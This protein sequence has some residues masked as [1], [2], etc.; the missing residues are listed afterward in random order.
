MSTTDISTQLVS[1]NFWAAD[2]LDRD[3]GRIHTK[4]VVSYYKPDLWGG[5]HEFKAGVD[6][7]WGWWNDGG[8]PAGGSS[9]HRAGENNIIYRQ[10][11]NN[12]VPFQLTTKNSPVKPADNGQYLGVYGPGR[13]DDRPTAD[14]QSRAPRRARSSRWGRAVLMLPRGTPGAFL[15]SASLRS[16]QPTLSGRWLSSVRE[17]P[18]NRD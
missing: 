16:A 13:V 4:G 5:N 18:G 17:R 1:G 8:I 7:L 12:G 2:G 9:G 14:T 6:H 3:M 10:V 11:Y 15:V